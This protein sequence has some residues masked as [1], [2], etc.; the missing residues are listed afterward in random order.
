LRGEIGILSAG[1]ADL[2]VAKKL[3]SLLNFLVSA[4]S[5]CGMLALRGF[6][7]Y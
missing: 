1:T 7:A 2:P 6:T 4:S 3:L 5:A